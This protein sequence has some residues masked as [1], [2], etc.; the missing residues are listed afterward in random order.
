LNGDFVVC[1]SQSTANNGDIV[2]AGIPGDEATIK[3]FSRSGNRITLTPS[4]SAMKPMVFESDEVVVYGKLV[5]VL[6]RL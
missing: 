1:N 3:T 2:I 4:N 6:R 5:T